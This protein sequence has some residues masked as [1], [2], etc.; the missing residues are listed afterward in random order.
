MYPRSLKLVWCGA[1]DWRLKRSADAK[2]IEA[3]HKQR[4]KELD[5]PISSHSIS[6]NGVHLC[7]EKYVAVPLPANADADAEPAIVS[8]AGQHFSAKQNQIYLGVMNAVSEGK[9]A[10]VAPGITHPLEMQFEGT[11]SVAQMHA[12][13][14]AK[15]GVTDSA[16]VTR[17]RRMAKRTQC[18]ELF[19]DEKR[20]LKD[21]GL[22]PE[23]MVCCT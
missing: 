15:L 6:E 21:C 10:A 4:L 22:L 14:R 8:I 2:Q 17:V 3:H 16:V 12:Q 11:Q 1:P 20:L 19:S 7:V 5:S 9:S 18:A 13:I 23:G